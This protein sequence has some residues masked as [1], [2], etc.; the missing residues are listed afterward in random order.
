MSPPI[1]NRIVDYYCLC[2]VTVQQVMVLS[3]PR[4]AF[5]NSIQDRIL[6]GSEQIRSRT[7]NVAV[8]VGP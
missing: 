7:K 2:E 1:E 3:E 4:I 6:S 8:A 5:R